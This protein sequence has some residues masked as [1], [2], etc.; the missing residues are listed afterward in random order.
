MG[1]GDMFAPKHSVSGDYYLMQ[2][3]SADNE[4]YLMIKGKSV[5]ETGPL[6]RFGW[7]EQYIVFTDAN[8][9]NPWN[10]IRVKEHSKFTITEAQRVTDPAFKGIVILSPQDA[11]N[12]K[13]R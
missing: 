2:G 12:T 5:S 6:H 7:N 4:V 10:V 9:P 8:W 3:E 13:N 1:W 11:W